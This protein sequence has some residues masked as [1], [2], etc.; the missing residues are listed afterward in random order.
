VMNNGRIVYSGTSQELLSD[1]ELQ[2]KLL[3]V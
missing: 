2:K 3:A 1:Q